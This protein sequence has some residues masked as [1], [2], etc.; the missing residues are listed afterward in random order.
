VIRQVFQPV[1]NTKAKH[2]KYEVLLITSIG[3]LACL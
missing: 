3:V 1:K 2:E